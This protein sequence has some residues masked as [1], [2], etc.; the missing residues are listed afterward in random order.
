MSQKR[1]RQ[2]EQRIDRIKKA[3]LQIGAMRRAR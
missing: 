2:I 1:A 3:L